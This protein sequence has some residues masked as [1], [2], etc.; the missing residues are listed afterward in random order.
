M[1]TGNA[2]SF[3]FT[4][5][6]KLSM[7]AAFNLLLLLVV[8]SYSVNRMSLIGMEVEE[9]SSVDMP[10]VL[11]VTEIETHQL[12]QA[13]YL[14][15]AERIA[16]EM[17]TNPDLIFGFKSAVSKIKFYSEKLS[18]EI[19]EARALSKQR[20][21]VGHSEEDRREAGLILESLS[22]IEREYVEYEANL[23]ELLT[24]I[25]VGEWDPIEYRNLVDIVD[26]E[27][28]Q[29][30]VEIEELLRGIERSTQE[31]LIRANTHEKSGLR[32]IVILLVFS[33]FLGGLFSF[34][35]TQSISRSVS[36]INAVTNKI[37]RGDLDQRIDRVSSD[38]IGDLAISINTLVESMSSAAEIARLISKGD[39]SVSI[40][41][42]SDGDKLLGALIDMKLQIEQQ[43]KALEKNDATTTAMLN[44]S[45][46][47]IVSIT[48]RGKILSVNAAIT[49]LFGY[50][51]HE[52]VGGNVKMLMPQ[53][54]RGEHDSYLD[55]YRN[56]RVKKV[57]GVGRELTGLRKD[58]STFPIFLTVGE[59]KQQGEV[60]FTGFVRDITKE[61]KFE[62]ELNR[63][64]DEL[65]TQNEYKT[66]VSKI[67]ELIQG[68]EDLQVM[69]DDI[70]SALAGMTMS[71]HGVLYVMDD[72]V[73]SSDSK[74]MLSLM[75]SYA[76]KN[77]KNISSI[78]ELGD[79]LIG[80][81]AKE[82]KPI[83]LSNAPKDYVQINSAL[84]EGTPLNIFVSPILFEDQL[85]GVIELA[86][87]SQYSESHQEIVQE[88]AENIGV[89]INSMLNQERT[90]KLLV[91][92]QRQ[93]EKL[94]T[95]QEELKS[96]NENLQEQ[97][98]LLRTSEREL[99]QQSEELK[100]SNEEL[101]E[102]QN[103][104]KEQK[105][106]I[107][108]SQKDLTIKANELTL[109]S[110]Y[111]SEF[112]ANMSHEL[113]TP[114]NSL[115]LLAKGLSENQNG[116]L[117]E[118]QVEDA[119]VIY[120]GGNSLLSLINDI[121]DLS[122][123]EAGKLTVHLEE[124]RFSALRMNVM[125]MFDPIAMNRNLT[126]TVDIDDTLP[127]TIITDGLRLEQ[128]LRNLL[129]NAMK[130]TSE[131]SV[132]L[133][134]YQPQEGVTFDHCGLELEASIAFSVIDT[135]VGIPEDKQQA[136]FEAFQQ[137]DGS[138]S[139]KYGGTGLGLT[140]ARELTR[141]LAGE[142][143]LSSTENMGSTFTLYVPRELT[144]DDRSSISTTLPCVPEKADANKA[145][146]AMR[147]L[148]SSVTTGVERQLYPEFIPD[149]RNT[150]HAGDK[151]LLVIEDDREFSL[152]LQRYVRNSGYKCLSAGDGRS[153]I[154]LAQ[155][156]QPDGIILDLGLP[157]IDGREVLQQL[158]FSLKTRGIPVQIVSGSERDRSMLL[159]QG[160][161]GYLTKPV[162][163]DQLSMV[164]NDISKLTQAK[165]K[166]ILVIEDDKTNQKAITQL[167]QQKELAITCVDTGSEGVDKVLSGGFDVVI[168]DLG[169]PDIDGF[170]VLERIKENGDLEKKPPIIIYTGKELSEK[171][172][173]QLEKYTSTIV[174]KGVGS[175]ERLLD[176]VS[177]FLHSIES[178]FDEKNRK[179]ISRLHDEDAM[180]KDRRI[181]LVDDDMRN[182]Y[183]LS[184]QLIE[185]GFDVEMASNGKDAL[186]I[187][188]Q[189]ENYEL[190]LM[191]TMMPVMD[192]NEAT[193]RIRQIPH[194]EALPIIALT[195]KTMPEDREKCLAAGASE[196]ITKP[197]D[198]EKLLSVIR[199]WLFKA[200]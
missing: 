175:P 113:R 108:I 183:A 47:G 172:Q 57:I 177:L 200:G 182:T 70:I 103:E 78:I 25:E 76:F 50:E 84:G 23:Y 54:F 49:K 115:L 138:T 114:L 140:I 116:N 168:L 39:F 149:D 151:I 197:I 85:M 136:I 96:S 128:I 198:F 2:P 30:S 118:T 181:L 31:S 131:G 111:K 188:E 80:Q 51:P 26:K 124:V 155:A 125:K 112:L 142:I 179:S 60:L 33:M 100:V 159:V 89:V 94:Q 154:F 119:K 71:G 141:L 3:R 129:S 132:S 193:I 199:I 19:T 102:K 58:R 157:D 139:R 162:N 146:V 21:G 86:S 104:L 62:M 186:E 194:Y 87:F 106:K 127:E 92:T 98:A 164:L 143:Q 166:N 120:S 52:L 163:E 83:L 34:F 195:A 77:R 1:S 65:L 18:I 5:G 22:S 167:L 9:I 161:I 45:A 101:E 46:D 53:P 176:D 32:G 82:K 137:Q 63:S 79:G 110:K 91:E 24:L 107:E 165:V 14:G 36:E 13:R 192:G 173:F 16:L 95:Q 7:A 178:R 135:G 134:V 29:L 11:S 196:Y 171:E 145:D 69:S 144:A 61:K 184:K 72:T 190:V 109:A 158:K 10:L 133:K 42:K 67:T 64:N 75:G 38:E 123:V 20:V 73:G 90:R 44:T 43:I 185:I 6:R 15:I 105:E 174:I 55:N 191:D 170:E 180:L 12:E 121:M 66:K 56:T 4:I 27:E 48:S 152:I 153:G 150:F 156:Y 117:S 147:D 40:T 148:T 8:G 17:K 97:T 99:Q 130:F 81:S 41:K 126:F 122:K 35:L 187:L 28:V 169:L 59:I 93:A 160:A 189:D 37:S 88:V 74:K 68:A